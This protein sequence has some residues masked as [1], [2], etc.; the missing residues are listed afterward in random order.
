MEER[1]TRVLTWVA[2]AI[3]LVTGLGYVALIITGHTDPAQRRTQTLVASYRQRKSK[4]QDL[5]KNR[6]DSS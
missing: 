1:S 4:R 3:A 6:G 2:I 5:E